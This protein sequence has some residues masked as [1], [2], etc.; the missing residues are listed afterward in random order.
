MFQSIRYIRTLPSY[1]YEY[2][3]ED[4]KF[5]VVIEGYATWRSFNKNLIEVYSKRK[6]NVAANLVQFYQWYD[7]YYGCSMA[8]QINELEKD[9][10]IIGPELKVD[11][12]KYLILL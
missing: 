5:S 2:V 8:N 12:Q 11:I 4:S 1:C 6:L 10:E 7:K 3:V 9:R